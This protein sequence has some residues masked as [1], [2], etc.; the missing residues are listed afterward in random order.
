MTNLEQIKLPKEFI[1]VTDETYVSIWGNRHERDGWYKVIHGR[2]RVIQFFKIENGDCHRLDGPAFI[3]VNYYG[4][5][6]ID[7]QF[8]VKN[9]YM[10]QE[11]YWKHPLVVEH[12][13][14]KIIEL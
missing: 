3:Q 1:Q 13:F 2:E 14:K 9:R 7:A 11:E 6:V 5:L 12:T 4:G 8:C 10:Q